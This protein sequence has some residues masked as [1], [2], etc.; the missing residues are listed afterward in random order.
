MRIFVSHS[1]E[2]NDF[3]FKL[4]EDLCRALEDEDAVW[5]DAS[6]GLKGGD[7]WWS[8]IVTELTARPVFILVLSPAALASRYVL[9][10]FTLALKQWHSLPGKLIIP[11]LYKPCEPREDMALFQMVSFLEP[12]PYEQ[13]LSELLMALG[14]FSSPAEPPR[15]HPA[16]PV[17]PP[18]V[19]PS[20]RFPP[21]LADLGY[22]VTFLNGA[23]VILPPLCDVP[24]GPFLMGSDPANDTAAQSNEQPQHWVTLLAY[25]IGKYPVTVAEYACFVRA[26]NSHKPSGIPLVT[27]NWQKQLRERLDHSVVLVKWRDAMAY[28]Q[29]LAQRTGDTW[30]LP[31][32]AEWEKAARWDGEAGIARRFPWGDWFSAKRCNTSEENIG[33]TTP[34]GSYPSGASPY[35]A[36]DMAG[37][38]WEWT[39]TLYNPYPYSATDGREQAESTGH[40]VLRG[41]SWY[42]AAGFARTAHR[43]NLILGFVNYIYGFRLVRS[44]S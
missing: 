10:E 24:A 19:A 21:R 15:A 39:N 9:T 44:A 18:H 1:H 7:E 27:M 29:W 17:A 26:T 41:G 37:N 35:G 11:V 25:Q 30:R 6:G 2:D 16:A 28:T 43:T 36:L 23:E 8:K 38:V 32:E 13:A 34:V 5:Y 42:V 31:S 14:L 3:G 33:S 20:G 12:K 4:V 40:R 22:R